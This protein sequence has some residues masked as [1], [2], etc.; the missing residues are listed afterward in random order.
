MPSH[1]AKGLEFDT[2]FIVNIQENYMDTDLD[3]KLLYVAM[4]RSL[5]ELH[6]Y[7]IKNKTSLLNNID[8]T[9]FNI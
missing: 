5:H 3:I 1:L 7:Q 6:I 8:D 2:V 9:F 4:T